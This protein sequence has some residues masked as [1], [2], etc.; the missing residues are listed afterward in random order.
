[1]RR[2]LPKAARPTRTA[3]GLA[4]VLAVLSLGL[5]VSTASATVMKYAD[6]EKLVEI[7]DII[8]Y[9]KVTDQ[10]TYFDKQQNRI[11]TDTTFTVEQNFLGKV[12]DKVT[13][14]QWG[15]T[16]KGKTLIIPGDAHFDQGEETIVFLHKGPDGVVALSALGQSKYSVVPT[17][18]GKLVSR[19]LS[20]IGFLI[21]GPDSQQTIKHLPN[22]TRSF[23][24]FVAELQSLV[25]G[26]K[27]GDHE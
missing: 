2:I 16:Y 13:I 27:G 21:G 17:K 10:K 1:M 26:I 14:Q 3:I 22:E 25:A 18:E 23:A 11:V 12:G 20:D 24:S 7:S 8:V 4:L 6:L 9:A 19:D 15:G 5:F